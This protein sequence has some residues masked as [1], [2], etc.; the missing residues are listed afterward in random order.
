MHDLVTSL[1]EDHDIPIEQLMKELGADRAEIELLLQESVFTKM[2][3]DEHKYSR[4]WGP[5]D[6]GPKIP[7]TAS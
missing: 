4:A 5:K 3:I 1:V 2:K 7:D 6:R